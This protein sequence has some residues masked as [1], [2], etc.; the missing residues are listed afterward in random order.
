MS[1][2]PM[3]SSLERGAGVNVRQEVYC[4]QRERVPDN[5]RTACWLLEVADGRKASLT[6]SA[7]HVLCG[8]DLCE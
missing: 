5:P 2:S 7:P 4:I 8:L 1:R 3:R 6:S